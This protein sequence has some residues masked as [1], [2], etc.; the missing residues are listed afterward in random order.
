MMAVSASSPVQHELARLSNR[1]EIRSAEIWIE[2][3]SGNTVSEENL[4]D[5]LAEFRRHQ[6]YGLAAYLNATG[7]KLFEEFDLPDAPENL[8]LLDVLAEPERTSL[9]D[10]IS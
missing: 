10:S 3:I 1:L 6:L 7:I 2:Q 4:R 9:P 5:L 8:Q